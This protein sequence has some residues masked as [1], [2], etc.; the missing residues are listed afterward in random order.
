MVQVAIGGY[1]D[2]N[3]VNCH[4]EVHGSAASGDHVDFMT[5]ITTESHVDVCGP[6]CHLNPC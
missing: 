2:V 3:D 5:H 6:C 4:F 1:V